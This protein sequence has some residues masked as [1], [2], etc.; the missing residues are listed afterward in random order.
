MCR[1][2]AITSMKYCWWLSYPCLSEYC[3]KPRSKRPLAIPEHCV[4]IIYINIKF[5]FF[6]KVIFTLQNLYANN[7]KHHLPI[8]KC[9]SEDYNMPKFQVIKLSS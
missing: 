5:R 6:N 1:K 4:K 3:Y 9:G 2:S 7:F 8:A